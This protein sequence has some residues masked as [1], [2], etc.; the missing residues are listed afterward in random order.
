[1]PAGRY[2]LIPFLRTKSEMG[3]TKNR[4]S[5]KSHI[6]H[7]PTNVVRI[8]LELRSESNGDY[9]KM[10]NEGVKKS[11]EKSKNVLE[12]KRKIVKQKNCIKNRHVY[13]NCNELH[14]RA[15]KNLTGLI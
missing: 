3:Q 11:F 14:S 9:S 5:K 8:A 7:K 1:M 4:S 2:L 15:N 12:E 13:N 10:K 6:K